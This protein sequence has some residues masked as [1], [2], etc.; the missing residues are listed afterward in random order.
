MKIEFIRKFRGKEVGTIEDVP[1]RVGHRFINRGMAKEVI[2]K[3][4][5]KSKRKKSNVRK[6]SK[7]SKKN[8]W[9]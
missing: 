6:L 5:K 9:K 7:I 4:V 8:I 3:V 2:T 1:D